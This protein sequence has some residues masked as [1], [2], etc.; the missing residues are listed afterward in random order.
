MFVHVCV[1]ESVCVSGRQKAGWDVWERICSSN[2][3][4]HKSKTNFM[5]QGKFIILY[6]V[7]HL[8]A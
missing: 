1:C 2:P 3:D 4:A 6:F 5:C 7:A 8:Y